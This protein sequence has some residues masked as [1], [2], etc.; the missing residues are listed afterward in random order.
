M[1]LLKG[2]DPEGFEQQGF[3]FAFSPPVSSDG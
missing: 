3:S 1:F 2:T